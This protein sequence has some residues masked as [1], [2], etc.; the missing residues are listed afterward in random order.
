MASSTLPSKNRIPRKAAI[1]LAS[2]VLAWAACVLYTFEG[3]PEIRFYKEAILLKRA[4]AKRLDRVYPAK[5]VV[6]GGSSCAFS[7]NGERMEQ[8]HGLPTANFGLHA[9]FGARFFS[10]YGL[11]ACHAGDNLVLALEPAL[12]TANSLEN[13]SL[14]VQMSYVLGETDLSRDLSFAPH[15][16]PPLPGELLQL[17]PGAQHV[18]TMLGKALSGQPW[19][20]YRIEEMRPSGWQSTAVRAELT[21]S[22]GNPPPLEPEGGALLAALRRLCAERQVHLLY[23]LPWGYCPPEETTS[24]RLAAARFVK[25][26]GA[27]LPVLADPLLGAHPDKTFFAD[28]GWHLTERGADARTDSFAELLR[29]NRCWDDHSLAEA[30]NALE[31]GEYAPPSQAGAPSRAE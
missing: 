4:W 11:K 30:R 23:S 29:A 12:L 6:V 9:G 22:P 7:I 5:T 19:Y 21:H 20:R 18:C 10:R 8:V 14:A 17:R 3:N 31:K 26:I 28:T 13:C 27:F 25:Q 24:Y 16:I 1:I 2:G 15:R